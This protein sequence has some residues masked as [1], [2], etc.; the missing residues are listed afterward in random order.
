MSQGLASPP[1]ATLVPSFPLYP[2]PTSR[3]VATTLGTALRPR[4]GPVSLFE[5]ARFSTGNISLSYARILTRWRRMIGQAGGDIRRH[6]AIWVES[7]VDLYC[8]LPR[9]LDVL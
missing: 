1:T 4:T 8:H 3:L 6:E 2:E 9:T 5:L 7:R